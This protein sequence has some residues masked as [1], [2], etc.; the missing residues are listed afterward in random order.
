MKDSGSKTEIARR[1]IENTGTSL[2]LTG[3]AG[4]G[5]TTFLKSLRQSTIKSCIV[6]APTGIAAINAGGVTLHSFFQLDFAPFVP[7]MTRKGGDR[8]SMAFSR[9][10][11]NIIRGLDLLVI[12]EISMVRSDT[13]DAIDAVLKR[14]RDRTL[15]FGGVQ[16]LL[17]GDLRQLP[18]VVTQ[19]D[20]AVLQGHYRSPYFF[21]S[22]ALAELDYVTVEL[23]KVYRQ[24][25]RTFLDL[26][27]AVR[28]GRMTPSQFA[29]LNSRVD[30]AF[31]PP[32]SEGYIRLVTHNREADAF[33]RE[34]LTA[35]P[36]SLRSFHAEVEGSFP[37]TSYPAE[38]DLILKV[39]AQVMFI[40]ND[41]GAERQ[42]YN[43][44]IGHVTELTDSGVTVQP[45]DGG[46]PVKV[47]PVEWENIK[48]E[49]DAANHRVVQKR[50]GSFRQI[51]L[52]TAWAITIHK[53][54]GL[55]FDKAVIDASLAFAHGQT[56]VALSRCRTLDGMVLGA[57]LS[58]RVLINDPEVSGYM[59]QEQLR[60]PAPGDIENLASNYRL[61]LLGK[62]FNFRPLA[63]SLEGVLRILLEN[64][65]TAFPAQTDTFRIA[66]E[67]FR[68]NCVEVGEKFMGQC[69]LLYISDRDRLET[70]I[71]DACRYFSAELEAMAKALEDL[72]VD[73]DNRAVMSR[74]RE[75]CEEASSLLRL[76]M[77]LAVKFKESGFT[78]EAYLE[79]KSAV[80][81]GTA[82]G[83]RKKG[84]SAPKADAN[85]DNLNPGLYGLLREWRRQR[86]ATASMPAFTILPTKTMLAISNAVPHSEAD[87]LAIPGLGRS[88]QKKYGAEILMQIR[89]WEEAGKPQDDS[90]PPI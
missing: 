50:E 16:L 76:F 68:Q 70:R 34:R 15:P 49:I 65:R 58:Q 60:T 13:L 54:Q 51:P 47:R 84:R 62:L 30:P 17:I 39:G 28:N 42:Y 35:L 81:L 41:A 88:R 5:K 82:Q 44:M 89:A 37:E 85:A 83:K 78:V 1:L 10:K 7:G 36:G 32:D 79:T 25:D 14:F 26:L 22:H 59:E 40:K 45:A 66:V 75:A 56:Y 55:T 31:N 38:S 29:A 74:F 63:N 23:D 3:R 53:S 72:G 48:F 52:K 4:T 61:Q 9:E 2:F 43:G 77:A 20:A 67:K 73:H 12:D 90:L 6:T 80:T 57:P 33:N 18:P 69:R 64:F 87:L 86:A 8:R 19:Q 21:D 11:I 46:E 24:S 27:N 71:K